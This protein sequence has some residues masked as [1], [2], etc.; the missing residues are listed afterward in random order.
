MGDNNLTDEEK[1]ALNEYLEQVEELMQREPEPLSDAVWDKVWPQ[2]QA[3]D[4]IPAEY[5]D[6]I[7]VKQIVDKAKG[8]TRN[9]YY[10][11]VWERWNDEL[12]QLNAKY[13]DLNLKAV[14]IAI[15]KKQDDSQSVVEIIRQLIADVERMT[16]EQ[17]ST[18][19]N[20]FESP[21]VP[22]YN[23]ALVSDIMQINTRGLTPDS[24]T[25]R[26]NIT[27]KDGHKITIENFDKLLKALSTPAKKI[28]NTAIMYLSDENFYNGQNITPTV[29]IPLI[30]YGEACDYQLTPQTMPTPE[31][32]AAENKAVQQRIK[33]FKKDVRRDLR[34]ISSIL[35][36]AEETKGR[37]K[38]DYKEMRIIS[39]HSIRKGLI[40]INFDIDAANYLV[41]SYVMQHPTALLKI[42]NRDH[43]SYVLGF[44]VAQHHSMDKNA[45]AGTSDTLSVKSL[46]ADAPEI[47]SIEKLKARGQRNWKD[48]IKRPLEKSLN[49]FVSVGMWSKWEYRDPATGETYTPETAQPMTWAQYSRLMVDYVM[50]DAPDQSERR[51]AKAEEKEAADKEKPKARRGRPPK[52]AQA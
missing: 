25:K 19:K 14:M 4:E 5:R 48:K 17:L 8:E 11:I 2:I 24:F 45:A 30:K 12:V 26:A 43:N 16:P 31:E 38:G 28:L 33:E 46:L 37:N 20:L 50:I 35:W 7:G 39:S 22:M 49:T 32:Q 44:K 15:T 13:H 10:D 51:A 23:G 6:R 34:D 42:D 29:E 41:H 27:T 1:A 40:R 3:T 47:Q 21:Y 18:V 36:T 52:N 9:T